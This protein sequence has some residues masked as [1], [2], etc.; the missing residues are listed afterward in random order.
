MIHWHTKK[1]T[2]HARGACAYVSW[3]LGISPS[4]DDH[5]SMALAG[6]YTV[7]STLL[8]DDTQRTGDNTD[9]AGL[10]TV[11]GVVVIVHT[12]F[13]VLA[14][15]LF[16]KLLE[17]TSYKIER[18]NEQEFVHCLSTS[19]MTQ[20]GQL[21]CA[22][23]CLLLLPLDAT[24]LSCDI[25]LTASLTNRCIRVQVPHANTCHHFHTSVSQLEFQRMQTLT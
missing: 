9:H 6:T 8:P 19:S 15:P 25:S 23:R 2:M 4:S 14:L 5:M 24:T 7:Q 11:Q 1:C 21:R 16:T 22:L 10:C 3:C 12:C 20:P 17:V 13:P 18:L